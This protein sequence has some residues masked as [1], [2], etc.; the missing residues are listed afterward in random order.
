M[1]TEKSSGNS[2]HSLN[3]VSC[4][5]VV[6]KKSSD[7]TR[8]CL[9]AR[10]RNRKQVWCLPKGHVEAGERFEETALREVREETGTIG[11]LVAPIQ[12]IAYRFYDPASRTQISKTVH[13][14]LIRY[15]TGSIE[16]HD[17]EVELVQWFSIKDACEHAIYAGEREV[18]KKAVKQIR[19]VE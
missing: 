13:F 11:T 3:Q 2:K 12:K 14:F 19:S 18:L 1:T 10:R 4:G 9:I 16:D 8:V 15:E 6:F 17:D 7:G 5:G